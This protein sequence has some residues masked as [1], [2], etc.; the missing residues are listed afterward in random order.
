MRG[1]PGELAVETRRR[2]AAS[3]NLLEIL[4]KNDPFAKA[5][6]ENLEVD[7]SNVVSKQAFESFNTLRNIHDRRGRR[8]LLV[9]LYSNYDRC[10][11]S[12]FRPSRF[13]REYFCFKA[14]TSR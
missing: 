10:S 1:M 9:E 3:K 8:R 5:D 12:A 2:G 4:I 14:C 7:I 13:F 11:P 6:A